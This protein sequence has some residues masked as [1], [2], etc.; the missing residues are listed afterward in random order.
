VQ[1]AVAAFGLNYADVMSRKGEYRDAPPLPAVIGYEVVGE[2]TKLGEGVSEPAVG[3]RVLAFTRFGG[4]ATVAVTDARAAVPLPANMDAAQATAL[5]TQ[6]C[7]AY[8]CAEELVRLHA[9]DHVLIHAAAG[10][11]GTLLVQ[12]ALHRGCTVFG[13]AGSA[14]KLEYLNRLGVQYPIN[15]RERDFAEEVR[16][17][18]GANERL[19]VAF[20]SLGG[21]TY[22]ESRKLLGAGG[23][24]VNYGVAGRGRGTLGLLGLLFRM[25]WLHPLFLLTSSQAAL[26]A[27]ML[28]IADYKPLILQRCLRQTV[29]LAEEGVLAPQLG[30]TYPARQLAEAHEQLASRQSTGKIAVVW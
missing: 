8:Y 19:D 25:G 13:T 7:T 5:A 17:R 22:R 9:G 26:G 29:A 28:R 4:Y 23:R 21:T 24:I 30:G 27:N 16:G 6:G 10:G 2:V 14:E 15:Y 11:V 20:D 3:T 1:V 12:L 18:L